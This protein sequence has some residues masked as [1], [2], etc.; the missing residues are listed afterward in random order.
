[1]KKVSQG[2]IDRLILY[3]KVLSRLRAEGETNVYSHRMAQLVDRTSAQVRRDI[4]AVGYSGT[5]SMGYSVEGLLEGVGDFLD[6]P[7]GQ[8]AA[9][10]GIG[11]LGRAIM[12]YTYGRHPRL[13]IVAAF[14]RDPAKVNRIIHGTRCY[15]TDDIREIVRREGISVAILAIPG[16]EAQNIVNELIE[17]G[18]TGI[19]NYTDIRLKTPE[20]VFVENRDMLR[21]L[22]KVAFFARFNNREE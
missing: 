21:A 22:E 5:P 1:M 16:E 11:N 9:M 2:T 15:H 10:I 19:L 7:K 12:D 6:D 20:N 3:R 8:K 14:D 4:M 18:V 13:S 17:A